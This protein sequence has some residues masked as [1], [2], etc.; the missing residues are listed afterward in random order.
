MKPFLSLKPVDE[1][2]KLIRLFP[3]RESEELLLDDCLGRVLAED[4][5]APSDLP[6]FDRSTVDGYAVHARDCFGASE[7]NPALL[8]IAPPT[9]MGE[10]NVTPL[11]EGEAAPILTGGMLPPGADACAM[12]EHTRLSGTDVEIIR[13][14]APGDH[15]TY[16]DED[17]SKGEIL[18]CKGCCLGAQEIGLLAAFGMTAVRTVR[19]PKTVIFS[20][21]DEIV[22][23]EVCPNPGQVR[24]VNAHAL[25]ALCREYG[26]DV[27]LAG[28]VKDDSK[29]LADRIAEVLP[30]TDIVVLSGGSSAGMRDHTVSVFS[31]FSGAELLVHGV[32]VSPGKPFI[33]A[34]LGRK[35]LMG[36]PG[37]VTSALITARLFLTP[38]L[39]QMQGLPTRQC[40]GTPCRLAHDTSSPLG[41]RDFIR[42]CLVRKKD[43]TVKTRDGLPLVKTLPQPSG[44]ITSLTRADGLV[45]CPEDRDGLH[46]GEALDLLPLY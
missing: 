32:A 12:V 28:I 15:V 2:L 23:I 38:L 45:V 33:L 17:A 4:V 16:H 11:A 39:R 29:V 13:P 7:S 34:S 37:H 35:C 31:G 1:V 24:D 9:P 5:T 22:P 41:R 40:P 44:C 26:A 8:R 6:G 46:A 18:L 21:G 42:V 36:L 25:L 3:L 20:T 27:R 10:P 14:V 19:R 43:G 30:G